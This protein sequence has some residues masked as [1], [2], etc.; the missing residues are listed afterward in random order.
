MLFENLCLR[1]LAVYSDAIGAKL[2]HYHD[3]AGLEV[4]AVLKAGSRWAAVEVK[5]GS[6]RVDEG[7]R[8]LRR[9]SSKLEGKGAKPPIWLAVLT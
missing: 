4:D 3:T 6:H 2:S 8:A 9:L 7:A 5:L 1:D